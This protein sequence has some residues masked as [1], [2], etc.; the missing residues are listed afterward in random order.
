[1]RLMRLL[2][3]VGVVAQ[4]PDVPGYERDCGPGQGCVFGTEWSDATDA[5]DSRNGCDTRNDVLRRDLI[6]TVIDP[7]TQ[8][9]VV[10][11][12]TLH[13]PYTGRA[14][15]FE[16]GWETS[17]AVQVDHVIPLA[18]AWD[19]GAWRWS[20][21]RRATFANDI[22]RELLA[23]GGP[24]N[25]SKGD[26][27]PASWLPPNKAFRCEYAVLYLRASLH[28]ALPITRAD[29]EVLENVARRCG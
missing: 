6:D 14:I 26:S 28:Y 13:D 22:R 9:C 5:P 16:R 15:P 27:T 25:M 3:Q 18:A 20:A 12:G 24:A 19:L 1:M 17:I 11:S 2:S 10:L 21:A 23:V 4:R 29:A 7:D 8:G